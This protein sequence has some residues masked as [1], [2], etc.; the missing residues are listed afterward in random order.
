MAERQGWRQRQQLGEKQLL[1]TS[2][3]YL[4][5]CWV[6]ATVLKLSLVAMSGGDLR[7]EMGRLLIAVISLVKALGT[8][9]SVVVAPG[10]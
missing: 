4:W 9:N 3:I 6:F 7:A 5:L 2:F 1:E 8:Q 10:L